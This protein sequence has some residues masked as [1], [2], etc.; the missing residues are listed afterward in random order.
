VIRFGFSEPG[1]YFLDIV[2]VCLLTGLSWHGAFHN[3][4]AA[5]EEFTAGLMVKRQTIELNNR[6]TALQTILGLFCDSLITLDHDFNIVEPISSLATLLLHTDSRALQGKSFL[7]IISSGKEAL[8]DAFRNRSLPSRAEMLPISLRDSHGLNCPVHA[9]YTCLQDLN[10]DY[11]YLV[12]VSESQERFA[13]EV[14]PLRQE[15]PVIAE[16]VHAPNDETSSGCNTVASWATAG[17]LAAGLPWVRFLDDEEFTIIACD[18]SFAGMAGTPDPSSLEQF[19]HKPST[20]FM[21]DIQGQGALCHK[22]HN[23]VLRSGRNVGSGVEYKAVAV[24]NSVSRTEDV[25]DLE[26][27]MVFEKIKERPWK[28]STQEKV[29]TQLRKSLQQHQ[30]SCSGM[31]G[32]S[33]P[34][35]QKLGDAAIDSEP[36]IRSL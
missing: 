25:R 34:T 18:P 30:P 27:E 17:N 6:E 29:N 13:T 19:L 4:Q 7:D 24:F 22:K 28:T 3:E 23:V 32:V 33:G 35:P 1:A 11:M 2:Y 26:F 14:R 9:C 15:L 20:A 8:V 21:Q 31:P 36:S 10:G 5:R 16:D 12:G